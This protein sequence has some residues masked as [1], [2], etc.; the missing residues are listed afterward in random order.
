MIQLKNVNVTFKQKNKEFHAVSDVSLN[1]KDGEIF[2]IM[3]ASGAGKS[4]LIRTINLLQRPTSGEIVI[5]DENITTY[6]GESL[7]R[8]RHSIGM[9]FQNFNLAES[10]TVFDNVA[11]PL[12]TAGKSKAEV[13]KRVRELLDLVG[14]ASKSKDY[15]SKLSGGQKQRVGIAR[16]LGNNTKILLCDEA[17][18]ALDIETTASILNILTE[19]NEKFKITIIIITHQLE[20]V[21]AICN[22]VAVMNH[23]RIVEEGL[24][25]DVFTNPKNEYTKKLLE[26]SS[27]F[28]LP[29]LLLKSIKGPIIK[30]KYMGETATEPILSNLL[31][32]FNVTFNILHGKIEYIGDLPFGILYLNIKGDK[33]NFTKAIQYLKNNTYSVEVI[34]HATT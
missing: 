14:L 31:I 12:K 18:S 24:V 2:G 27:K 25:Y 7:R 32:K 17:T 11:F 8:L 1:I 26:H 10:K 19:I 15:P 28:E 16:A 34:N 4:T 3:G 23:G 9:I 6:R 30:I 13:N 20:V 5:N 29:E 21:K 33:D 22:R